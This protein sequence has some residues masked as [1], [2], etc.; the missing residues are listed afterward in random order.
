MKQDV[1]NIKNSLV[2]IS[3][4]GLD[5]VVSNYG[6]NKIYIK[7]T[8][9]NLGFRLKVI[10]DDILAITDYYRVKGFATKFLVNDTESSS[11]KFPLFTLKNIKALTI[12]LI[13]KRET[14]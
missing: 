4:I 2:S 1:E 13:K 3:D 11:Y 7:V 10:R 14:N 9:S 5:I 6:K 12:I 8:N